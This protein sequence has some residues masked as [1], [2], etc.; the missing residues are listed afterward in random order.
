MNI[1]EVAYTS[2]EEFENHKLH[3]VELVSN[4]TLPRTVS[5][6]KEIHALET[7]ALEHIRKFAPE[8]SSLKL[9]DITYG[10]EDKA[11][12]AKLGLALE[13]KDFLKQNNA[14]LTETTEAQLDIDK[15]ANNLELKL[16]PNV[17]NEF[18]GNQPKPK[19][20][21][22]PKNESV[23]PEP[24]IEVNKERVNLDETYVA[25]ELIAKAQIDGDIKEKKLD[26]TSPTNAGQIASSLIVNLDSSKIEAEIQKMDE[27]LNPAQ[28]EEVTTTSN[29]QEPQK[30]KPS[31]NSVSKKPEVKA[32][33]ATPKP[34]INLQGT[35]EA[36]RAKFEIGQENNPTILEK[37]T[38]QTV[39]K[40]QDGRFKYNLKSEM[41]TNMNAMIQKSRDGFS[42][43]VVDTPGG[44]LEVRTKARLM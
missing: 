14:T 22:K 25:Q 40:P 10:E 33:I 11:N 16:S 28:N 3:I 4:P 1:S 43:E 7:A 36:L 30:I 13:K 37:E 18:S 27:R 41:V 2:R 31:P 38:F 9:D 5:E 39:L 26:G 29:K 17:E 34:S 21:Y 19:P 42:P 20:E 6:R 35:I 24:I 8:N 32:D 12:L 23:E 15:L 44:P